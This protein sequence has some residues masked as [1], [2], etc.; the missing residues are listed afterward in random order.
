ML[1]KG[2]PVKTD[3]EYPVRPLWFEWLLLSVGDSA[4]EADY[5]LCCG[6]S[7]FPS[8]IGCCRA[9]SAHWAL[10]FMLLL[11]RLS[12]LQ[13]STRFLYP[14]YTTREP[15]LI[16]W[17]RGSVDINKHWPVISSL[18]GT[19]GNKSSVNDEQATRHHQLQMTCHFTYKGKK[20]YSVSIS[21]P[22]RCSIETLTF[23]QYLYWLAEFMTFNF[24]HIQ[25]QTNIKQTKHGKFRMSSCVWRDKACQGW[26]M[27]WT[28]VHG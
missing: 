13:A 9:F 4:L 10:W 21:N 12:I 17:G 5:G 25:F 8:L 27:P 2:S 6:K 16:I 26:K 3:R 24:D 14:H 15:Y 20:M 28:T 19:W 11:P 7:R 18:T 23:L 1:S 22:D